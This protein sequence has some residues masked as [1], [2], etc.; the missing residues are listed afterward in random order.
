MDSPPQAALTG[1]LSARYT[2]TYSPVRPACQGVPAPPAPG[3]PRR[4]RTPWAQLKGSCL[5][6]PFPECCHRHGRPSS[7]GRGDCEPANLGR[8]Q[9]T[10]Q[11]MGFLPAGDR[12]PSGTTHHHSAKPRACPHSIPI[13][14]VWTPSGGWL[15]PALLY[16]AP[17][18]W[19]GFLRSGAR[20]Q[21]SLRT[22]SSSPAA[23]TLECLRTLAGDLSA[24]ALA[25]ACGFRAFP[26]CGGAVLRSRNACADSC[27]SWQPHPAPAPD[28]SLSP[29]NT[30]PAA[31]HV[32]LIRMEATF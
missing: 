7:G 20:G 8:N 22:A 23:L 30:R 32:D 15:R 11:I 6:A 10:R 19:G 13:H 5:E 24:S 26:A 29:P 18:G 16:A 25:A 4:S 3:C 21:S 12:K 28:S 9:P 27:S 14:F 31:G 1:V 17:A 2:H